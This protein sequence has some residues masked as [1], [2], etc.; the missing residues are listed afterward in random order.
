MIEGQKI[1]FQLFVILFMTDY[2]LNSLCDA[3]RYGETDGLQIYL[4]YSRNV[5][6]WATM[7]YDKK[8]QNLIYMQM[9]YLTTESKGAIDAGYGLWTAIGFG[10]NK[11]DKSDIVVCQ[12]IKGNFACYDAF[13]SGNNIVPDSSI[14]LR[15]NN[16]NLLNSTFAGDLNTTEFQNYNSLITW[17]FTK[18]ISNLDEHDWSVFANWTQNN[19]SVAGF[20]GSFGSANAN[21]DLVYSYNT[22]DQTVTLMDGS[23]APTIPNLDCQGT[24]LASSM[25]GIYVILIFMLF[26]I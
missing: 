22:I 8:N 9:N 25:Y 18:D 19:A 23:N 21:H 14:D 10:S 2:I 7:D 11:V 16:V 4:I 6:S 26:L 13:G 12:Y 1:F 17:N 3:I 5:F 24:K 15:L 20:S